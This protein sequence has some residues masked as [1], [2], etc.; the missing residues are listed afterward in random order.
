MPTNLERALAKKVE[1]E[2]SESELVKTAM[3]LSFAACLLNILLV[4]ESPAFAAAVNCTA[5]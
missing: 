4:L 5:R 3:L 1:L 2:R